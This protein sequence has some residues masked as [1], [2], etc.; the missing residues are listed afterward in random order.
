MGARET[1]TVLATNDNALDKEASATRVDTALASHAS[2]LGAGKENKTAPHDN[3]TEMKK[4]EM[5][6]DASASA[7][8]CNGPVR[9][10]GAAGGGAGSKA[11]RQRLTL[12]LRR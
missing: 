9:G 3:L 1:D 2:T 7:T 11:K 10:T 6:S 8:E 5:G 12:G 4:R